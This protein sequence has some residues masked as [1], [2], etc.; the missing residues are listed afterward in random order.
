MSQ[1]DQTIVPQA[2]AVVVEAVVV[3]DPVDKPVTTLSAHRT[4]AELIVNS[5]DSED[6]KKADLAEARDNLLGLEIEIATARLS[7]TNCE[8][9]LDIAEQ[10]TVGAA[11][12]GITIL[13]Q[14]VATRTGAPA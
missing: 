12:E 13:Q 6:Q 11:Q 5:L 7:V 3:E 4:A 10:D 1:A 14:L 2:E 8:A 9:A